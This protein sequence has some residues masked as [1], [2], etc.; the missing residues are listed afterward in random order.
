VV[1]RWKVV[2]ARVR[3][4]VDRV[5]SACIFFRCTKITCSRSLFYLL[6]VRDLG[7]IWGSTHAAHQ[8]VQ[9]WAGYVS[10]CIP[11]R[12]FCF[13]GEA[14]AFFLHRVSQLFSRTRAFTRCGAVIPYY[15]LQ[16]A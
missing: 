14:S 12:L 10:L 9:G 7:L 2:G 15:L 8:G 6:P 3:L 1:Q 13:E 4:L 11:N 5:R 16:F